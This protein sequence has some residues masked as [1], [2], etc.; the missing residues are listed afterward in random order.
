MA[1]ITMCVNED[2][3]MSKTCYRK[4]AIASRH[5]SM[6]LFEWEEKNGKIE[7]ESFIKR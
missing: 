6:A 2:C 1:D 5:Q 4:T 3:P 7:C